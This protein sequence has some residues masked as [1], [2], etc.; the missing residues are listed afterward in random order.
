LSRV[1]QDTNRLFPWVVSDFGLVEAIESGLMKIPQLAVRDNTGQEIPGYF[2]IWN[3][4][5][6]QL[7]PPNAA[8]PKPTRNPKRF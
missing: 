4:I 3:W 8:E 1:G 6:L 5:L 2:N 7:T